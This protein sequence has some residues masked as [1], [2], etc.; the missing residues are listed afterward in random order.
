MILRNKLFE[1]KMKVLFSGKFF[2]DHSLSIVNRN[3]VKE[4][5][6]YTDVDLYINVY[7]NPNEKYEF[8]L[9]LM[10]KK[11]EEPDVEIRHFYPPQWR[12]PI[13]KT[14]LVYIQPYEFTKI[15]F[16]WIYRFETISSHLIVPSNWC[17][18]VY[19]NAGMD[20]N[21]VTVIP[22]GVDF[23]IFNKNNKPKKKKQ[24]TFLYIGCHQFRKGIDVLLKAWSMINTKDV[25]LII[26]DTPQIYGNNNLQND[27][28]SLKN[29]LIIKEHMTI[30]QMAKLYKS[31]DVIIHPYR[32]EGFGMN[33]AEG[34]ACG[35]TPL[36][37]T[38]GATDDFVIEDECKIKTNKKMIDITKIFAG[39]PG[40]S[41]SNMGSHTFMFEPDLQ[42][43]VS[44]INSFIS[45]KQLKEPDISNI[46]SWKEVA[47]EYY[48]VIKNVLFTESK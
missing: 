42:D 3:V 25:Q 10:S 8:L 43:L 48:N 44:K 22:N 45:L 5:I 4:L 24:L 6:K 7:D 13:G 34:M 37:S 46:K 36:V 18:E 14:K 28:K 16:E 39:K 19:L 33:V 38:P 41:F 32:G 27:I 21:K 2:D 9:N 35:L 31:S 11:V 20:P 26:K 30:E 23:D 47:N 29:V 15:P 17:R 1:I 40:D 12:R